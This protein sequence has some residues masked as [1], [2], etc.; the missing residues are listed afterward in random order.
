MHLLLVGAAPV[1]AADLGHELRGHGFEVG[2]VDSGAALLATPVRA[3]LVLLALDL[4]DLDGLEVCR[5]LRARSQVP[6][7]GLSGRDSELDR[8]LGLQAGLDDY[9][10]APVRARELVAV[11]GAVMRRVRRPA[12]EA[13]VAG[14][15]IVHGSLHIGLRR[16]GGSRRFADHRG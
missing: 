11:I 5:R 8:V 6:I 12:G 9:V 4:P 15:A 13:T 14:E 2:V 7:I 16:R 10:S 3:D 1:T